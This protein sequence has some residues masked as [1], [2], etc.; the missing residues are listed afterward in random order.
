MRDIEKTVYMQAKLKMKSLNI[1]EEN[2]VTHI[3]SRQGKINTIPNK[4]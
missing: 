3:A 1:T 2:K 4:A